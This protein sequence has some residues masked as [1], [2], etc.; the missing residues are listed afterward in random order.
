LQVIVYYC[1]CIRAVELII[2]IFHFCISFICWYEV[3]RILCC[4]FW[5]L[6]SWIHLQSKSHGIKRYRNGS[7]TETFRFFLNTSLRSVRFIDEDFFVSGIKKQKLFVL[8]CCL[9]VPYYQDSWIVITSHKRNSAVIIYLHLLES[10]LFPY[11]I[12]LQFHCLLNSTR[13]MYRTCGNT[14]AGLLKTEMQLLLTFWHPNFTFKFQH[15]LY[16]KCE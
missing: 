5:S 15:T 13:V 4:V 11:V 1:S 9:Q 14:I 10:K 16:V 7:R 3:I 2:E 12:M 6:Y 8:V